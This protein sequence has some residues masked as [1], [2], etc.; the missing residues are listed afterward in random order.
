MKPII[1]DGMRTP[2]IYTEAQTVIPEALYERL[3]GGQRISL[4]FKGGMW[5]AAV[6]A[7][8]RASTSECPGCALQALRLA[9]GVAGGKQCPACE[10]GARELPVADLEANVARVGA[11]TVAALVKTRGCWYLSRW[12]GGWHAEFRS[13]LGLNCGVKDNFRESPSA[14][15]A[16]LDLTSRRGLPEWMRAA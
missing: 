7:W 6:K 14:V 12:K 2:A 8:D 13:L 5:E 1:I 16:E 11:T 10:A 4:R 3:K 9:C 15:C